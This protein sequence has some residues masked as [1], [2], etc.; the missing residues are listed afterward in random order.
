MRNKKKYYLLALLLGV[1]FTLNFTN[2]DSKKDKHDL[3]FDILSQ[4]TFG[5][6]NIM[7]CWVSDT[8]DLNLEN[9]GKELC[10]KDKNKITYIYFYLDKSK[11]KD[12]SKVDDMYEAIQK[13]GFDA[14]YSSANGLIK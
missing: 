3:K 14:E 9:V 12:I 4:H 6:T 2:C 8:S 7:C 13:D 1:L 10:M 5:I 11:A